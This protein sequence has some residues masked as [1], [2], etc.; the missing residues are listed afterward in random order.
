MNKSK[1][2]PTLHGFSFANYFTFKS[3]DLNLPTSIKLP[4]VSAVY[5]LCGGMS[6]SVCDYFLAGQPIPKIG[7]RPPSTSALF[8]YL[9][10]RQMQSFGTDGYTVLRL[11]EWMARPTNSETLNGVDITQID[12]TRELTLQEFNQYVR[13]RLDEGKPAQV[14]LVY[15]SAANTLQIWQNHQVLPYSYEELPNEV[16]HIHIYD[17]NYPKRDDVYIEAKKQMVGKTMFGEPIWG[18]ACIRK[19]GGDVDKEIRGFFHVPYVYVEPPKSV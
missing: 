3:A 5:G 8:K 13:P 1:F 6:A 4:D 16:Y 17:P 9:F 10:N 15:V 18:L 7:E 11:I 2:S 14:A 12:S 19:G